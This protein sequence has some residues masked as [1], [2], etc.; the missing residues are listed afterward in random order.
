M[1]RSMLL[2]ALAVLALVA[3]AQGHVWDFFS[4]SAATSDC[5]AVPHAMQTDMQVLWHHAISAGNKFLP[6]ASG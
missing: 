5:S 3:M 4:T 2:R 6:C 1:M